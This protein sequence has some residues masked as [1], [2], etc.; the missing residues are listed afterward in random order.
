M[1]TAVK[2][3][4]K[5]SGSLFNTVLTN[6]QLPHSASWT[7]SLLFDF[8]LT[9]RWHSCMHSNHFNPTLLTDYSADTVIQT[10]TA[11]GLFTN[12]TFSWDSRLWYSGLIFMHVLVHSPWCWF[13]ESSLKLFLPNWH[14]TESQSLRRGT[15][16][17]RFD[18]HDQR[19]Q[20]YTESTRFTYT[21]HSEVKG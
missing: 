16:R 8:Q 3:C 13:F 19:E 21:Q 17:A 5:K 11:A 14:V 1:L 6:W 18:M 12:T 9:I 7:Y 20:N 10:C 4:M 2:M 15:Y